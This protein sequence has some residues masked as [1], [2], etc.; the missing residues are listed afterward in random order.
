MRRKLCSTQAATCTSSSKEVDD[1]SRC[2]LF[3]NANQSHQPQSHC[4]HFSLE[5]GA[6]SRRI[7]LTVVGQEG[8]IAVVEEGSIEVVEEGNIEVVEEVEKEPAHCKS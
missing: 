8:N 5:F 2:H 3:R 4:T 1:S 6:S 7:K